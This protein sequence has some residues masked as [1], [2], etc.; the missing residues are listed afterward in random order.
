M[1][2][3]DYH[4]EQCGELFEAEH[5]MEGPDPLHPVICPVC[6]TGD[7]NKVILSAPAVRI[8]FKNPRLATHP[9]EKTP[10]Y[11]P[12]VLAKEAVDGRD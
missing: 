11:M 6:R 8:W 12:P 4:C 2:Y 10:K 3:Y 9:D 7:V 5:G 1:P